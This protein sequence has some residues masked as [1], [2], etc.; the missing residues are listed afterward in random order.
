MDGP[1]LV[2]LIF[3]P[4]GGEI[5][6]EH[7]ARATELEVGSQTVLVAS[8]DDVIVT[9][10]LALTEQDPDFQ[11]VLEVA[12]A[13]REQIDWTLSRSARAARRSHGRSSRSS[14][15]SG[16]SSGRA[17][18]PRRQPTPERRGTASAVEQDLKRAASRPRSSRGVRMCSRGKEVG[19]QARTGLM[20]AAPLRRAR[21]GR[22]R[23]REHARGACD[24]GR[25]RTVLVVLGITVLVGLVA[26]SATS[27]GTS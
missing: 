18:S 15:A 4:A 19:A 26:C 13:L 9:K 1:V 17:C 8:I 21:D 25:P 7:F 20:D 12:R 6:D 23:C 10:L 3:R 27:P 24:R 22:E 5:D 14:R 2:D 16:S 11:A